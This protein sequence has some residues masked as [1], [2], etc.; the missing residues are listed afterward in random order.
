MSNSNSN[1][2][3]RDQFK[4]HAIRVGF[5]VHLTRGMCEFLSAVADGVQWDR[6]AFGS[7]AAF[8]DNWLSTT[9]ALFK[10]GLIE[11]KPDEE[12]QAG[13]TRPARDKFEIHSWTVWQLTPA[14]AHVV[15][16]LKLAGMFV[17]ADVAA[18]KKARAKR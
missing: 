9:Q 16:L 2:A 10:R 8:P 13:K 7:C 3:W 15:E 6:A 17:E 11:R 18:E 14:G 1:E 4:Q 5:A 12:L